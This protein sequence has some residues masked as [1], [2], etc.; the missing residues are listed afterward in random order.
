M[1][2]LSHPISET[3]RRFLKRTKARF[4]GLPEL[5]YSLEFDENH[6]VVT[7]KP[8]DKDARV[9]GI[10]WKDVE[11]VYAY[12]KDCVTVDQ[13]RMELLDHEGKGVVFTEEM[14][15]WEAVVKALPL[16]LPACLRSD[17]WFRIVA[18]SAFK[19]NMTLLYERKGKKEESA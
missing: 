4:A 1:H 15:G 9:E 12:K 8:C 7:T 14:P 18:V 10:R 5:S 11:R 6:I 2:N 16:R 19:Q 17:E 13:I 3:I